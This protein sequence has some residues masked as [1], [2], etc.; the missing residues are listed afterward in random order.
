MQ[1]KQILFARGNFQLLAG[2]VSLIGCIGVFGF[3]VIDEVVAH[4]VDGLAYTRPEILHLC[5]ETL[6]VIGLAYAARQLWNYMILLRRQAAAN[7]AS[8]RML[9]GEFQQVLQ[10]RFNDWQL[11]GAEA[12]VALMIVKGLN[13]AEISAAR[14]TAP[15]TI[16]AQTSSVF[17]KVG[18]GSKSELMAAIVEEFLESN[19]AGPLQTA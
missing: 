10:A 13:I 5:I 11:T 3:D 18:V 16:K 15:G 14:N 7:E 2:A 17:R 6:G 9:R 8:L 4:A 12:D 19:I 1:A